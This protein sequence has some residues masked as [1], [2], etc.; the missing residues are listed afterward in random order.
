MAPNVI[1]LRHNPGAGHPLIDGAAALTPDWITAV[2]RG[3][4]ILD[5]ARVSRATQTPIGNGLLGLNLQ[6]ALEYDVTEPGAPASLVAKM[7]S[8][9]AESRESGSALGLYARETRFY[10]ELA[11]DLDTGLAR[12]LFADVAE[13]GSNFCL[14]FEDLTPA[15]GGDQLAGCSVSEAVAA[16]DTAAALHAP[17]WNDDTLLSLPWV[18]RDSM[19]SMYVDK[20]PASVDAVEA[21]FA[22]SLEPG[23]IDVAR[24]FG[25]RVTRYFELHARPWTITHQDFRLD[26]VLFD[27]RG[28]Q[29]SPRRAR[30]AD[31]P[32]RSGCARRGVLPR[33]RPA[34]ADAQGQRAGT[35]RAL[36]PAAGRAWSSRL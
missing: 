8:S 25:A 34:A 32:A 14:L 30:L 33:S 35:R 9:R 10:Q 31:V 36:S 7:A 29:T 16:M 26:N 12:T 13:D 20:L 11:P 18:D 17:F 3:H 23:V 27:A 6:L 19:V 21:R 22:A 24:R 2:L 5:R 4:G 15:R 28:G 1:P